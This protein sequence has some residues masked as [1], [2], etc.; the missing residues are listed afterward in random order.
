MALVRGGDSS[1]F[2][3]LFRRHVAAAQFVARAQT[4]NISDADDVV[5]EAFASIFQ[6]L[7]E[8]K[9]PDQFF[10]SYLLTAVR[11]IAYDRNR[12]ARRTQAVGDVEVLDTVAVD[13]DSVLEAFES[14]TMA[15]AFK[16]LPERWQAVLWHMDIEGLKPAAAAPFIG[17]TPNGV[18][19]LVIRAREG[20]RQAYLQNHISLSDD[21]SCFEYSSQLGKYARDGLKRTSHE[22]VK[23]H[24]EECPKCTAL[25]VE[26]NDVQGGMRAA[27]FPLV[28]GVVFTPA[29][30]TGFLPGA[31]LSGT[32]LPAGTEPADAGLRS[33]SG[34]WKIAV[35]ALILGGFIV[36]G[37][38][39][40]LGQTDPAPIAGA[41]VPSS[42][43]SAQPSVLE[44]APTAPPSNPPTPD[45]PAI[46]VPQSP[47][48]A[49]SAAAAVPVPQETARVAESG[50]GITKPVPRSGSLT[51]H[52]YEKPVMPTSLPNNGTALTPTR[53]AALTPM[54]G[55]TFTV[56]KVNNIDLATNAGWTAAAA[57]TPA[58]AATQ[59]ATPGSATTTDAT[60][61]ATLA[62][63]PLGLYL[64]TETGY[65][66]GVT[67]ATPFLVTLPM[68]DPT[69]GNSWLYDVNV[70]PKNAVTTA[71]KTVNDASV[72][73][74]GDKVQWNI[75]SDIPNVN[76]IDGYRIVDKLDPKLTYTNPTVAL[77]NN[78]ALTL[79]TDYTI[80][81]DTATN[82]LTVDFTASGRAI[83]ATDPTAKVQ[84]TVNTTVNTDG[85]ISNTALVYP[86]AASFNITPG[87]P[88][89]P[90]VTPP[91]STTKWG[92]IVLHKQDS[93]SSAALAG[94]TFS[95]YATQAD[96]LAGTNAISVGG[97]SSWTTDASGKLLIS[98]LRYSNW[99]NGAAVSPG[100]PGYQSYWLVE[101][102]APAGYALL[103][104]PVETTV[105][106]NDPSAVTVTIDNI[107]QNAE[108]Q[109]PLTGMRTWA[110]PAGGILVLAGAGL[111]MV[112]GRR[113]PTEAQ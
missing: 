49:P 82:T 53:L 6:A 10:R 3:V 57:L 98:G 36:A 73:K 15:K 45:P 8:G 56:Q 27:V 113:Q 112:T 7:T 20:L 99:A 107:K 108:F 75:T 29:V 89:G 47:A 32:F 104:Q 23:A 12:K 79:N 74:L 87:Q 4:D 25:F 11:R 71:T 94:A 58:Q 51:I 72:V 86:N 66:A 65:P 76:P 90:V 95:V 69:G 85:H 37:V 84:V 34:F 109:L 2:D 105:T 41:D 39:T 88:N 16:S 111:F 17:L 67:P 81:F 9:G 1:V 55:V 44:R 97:A 52:K 96:A 13:A 110:L 63:L 19:S 100:Q 22:K 83:L 38:L 31:G 102:K 60:G 50:T 62:D 35:G 5:A 103:A 68:T 48:P 106:S 80:V 61:T 78:A 40:W 21:D 24:L 64:V 43:P 91:V 77:S 30:T 70:Y 42:A 93:Q 59:A 18:S 46:A 92:D 26:L 101:T 14:S 54:A 28:A 33:V